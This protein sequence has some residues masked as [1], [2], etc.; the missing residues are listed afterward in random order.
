M[1]LVTASFIQRS[2]FLK[3]N[4]LKILL[5]IVRD[6]Y[7]YSHV[8]SERKKKHP[9]GHTPSH[10]YNNQHGGYI[11]LTWAPPIKLAKKFIYANL[12]YQVNSLKMSLNWTAPSFIYHHCSC[13]KALSLE[14]VHDVSTSFKTLCPL[15]Y[16]T[17]VLFSGNGTSIDII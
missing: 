4:R 1:S 15:K 16:T 3:S 6:H 5:V 13:C 17:F 9:R 7:V 12:W 2:D 14:R 10:G 11:K 8:G